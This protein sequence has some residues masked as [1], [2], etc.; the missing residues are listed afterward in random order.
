[1]ATN[2]NYTFKNGVNTSTVSNVTGINVTDDITTS[3]TDF[4]YS[5]N[6][7]SLINKSATGSLIFG[8][9]NSTKFT[10]DNSGNGTLTGSLSAAGITSTLTS[11]ATRFISN[12]A[13]GTAPLTVTS[14]TAVTNLNADM[15][16]GK[17]VGTSGNTIPVLD[18]VNSWTGLQTFTDEQLSA[19]SSTISG[20]IVATFV[21]DTRND[22]DS[23][24][25]RKRCQHTSW[26]NETLN[27]A[28]RGATREFPAVAL[29]VATSS[30]VTIYDATVSSCP[31]WMV[32]NQT[33]YSFV[34]DGTVQSVY[35]IA[36]TIYVGLNSSNGLRRCDFLLDKISVLY[37]S[38]TS[39]PNRIP[40]VANRHNTSGTTGYTTVSSNAIVN[41]YVN[42]I[43]A[44]VLLT[45][46]IDAA[47]G[48]PIPTVWVGTLGGTSRISDSGTVSNWT[49]TSGA[50]VHQVYNIGITGDYVYWG[51]DA[52][53][54]GTRI[55]SVLATQS[56]SAWTYNNASYNHL[57][58]N[59]TATWLST[60]T[61]I[62]YGGFASIIREI[63]RN[64][65]ATNRSLTVIQ[66][67][68]VDWGKGLHATITKDFNTGYQYGDIRGAWLCNCTAETLTAA[69]LVTGDSSTFTSGAG[70][71][72]SGSLGY[73]STIA[74][75]GGKLEVTSLGASGSALS[76]AALLISCAV[77]KT[78]TLSASLEKITGR[79]NVSIWIYGDNS[80]LVSNTTIGTS[81]VTS[82]FTATASSHYIV[83]YESGAT[84]VAGL[85]LR[86]D[87]ITVK[88]ADP[89]YSYKNQ[90]LEVVGSVTKAAVN[91]GCDLLGYSGYSV[92][93][94]LI[95]AYN[96]AKDFSTAAFNIR[97]WLKCSATAANETILERDSASTAQRFTVEIAATT[98]YMSFTCD[99]N[100]TTRT[101]TS[102]VAVDDD[103][104]HFY[105]CIYNGAG[106]V[107]IYRD[108]SSTAFASATGTAL[109][110]LNNASATLTIGATANATIPLTSGILALLHIGADGLS[111]PQQKFI[112]EQ[113][114]FLFQ[115]NAKCL[116]AGTSND[117]LAVD[118]DETT[119]IHHL[120]TGDY[121]SAFKGLQRVDSASG[122]WTSI[123]AKNDLII[124]GA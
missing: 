65:I 68:T 28:T 31:M 79:N 104:W 88:L 20:T 106:G 33:D 39:E 114:K 8:T 22:S 41:N 99:D 27:T 122:V 18:G 120:V 23:G 71:W 105:E 117:V 90:P 124:K 82:S 48:L 83:V 44:T 85:S 119:G 32:F 66:P 67:N 74:T 61:I 14:T 73:D 107:Y 5:A 53:A 13:I 9:N 69:S 75:V 1:M 2:T 100:T 87:N 101:A 50:S 3:K 58:A 97:F 72:V 34:N 70:S 92:S 35:A 63:T 84:E 51:A 6:N 81:T 24:A 77:G 118:Y 4:S 17:H 59:E 16:D 49:D 110:T 108:G 25:W 47:T 121:Y 109:L 116:L 64:A 42:C 103:L 96:S 55:Q 62:Y 56:L 86:I 57:D 111:A 52:N 15:V 30:S 38:G 36:G 78:Y 40:N 29:I 11:T 95:E 21:Y 7:L 93:N 60:K 115:T 113:E 94:Y 26:Y 19:I 89:D 76:G 10:I 54:N 43:T 98:S 46:P 12:V 91:T 112:Y 37:A 123:S 80:S 45:A 102:A